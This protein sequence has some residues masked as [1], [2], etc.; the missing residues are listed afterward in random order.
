MFR[1]WKPQH[2]NPDSSLS[3]IPLGWTQ[4]LVSL[5]LCARMLSCS[6]LSNSLQPKGL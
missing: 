2:S 4:R 1:G 6:V 5:S 3:W